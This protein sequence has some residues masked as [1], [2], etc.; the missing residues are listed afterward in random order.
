MNLSISQI[1]MFS[2]CQLKYYFAKIEKIKFP[3]NSNLI[4][5]SATHS[6]LQNIYENKQQGKIFKE[7]V[8]LDTARDYVEN[9]DKEEEIIWE[10]PKDEA[11]NQCIK[12]LEKYIKDKHPENIKNESIVSVENKFRL[13]VGDFFM[14]CIADLELK[15]KIIDFKT[16]KRSPSVIAPADL[17]QTVFYATKRDE[18]NEIEVQYLVKLKTEAKIVIPKIHHNIKKLK[19]IANLMVIN[20]GTAIQN[21]IKSDNF[22]ATG[23]THPWACSYC[24]YGKEGICDIYAF[25]KKKAVK[26]IL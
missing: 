2:Q 21:A 10:I 11:K 9:S 23:L 6:G 14:W 13:Q 1:K 12:L 25:H 22:V 8:V 19:P 16:A 24:D 18:I 5:G 15:N 26:E 7:S 4:I 20:T 17:F 3:V